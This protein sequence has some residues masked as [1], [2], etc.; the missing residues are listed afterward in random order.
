MTP[1][2]RLYALSVTFMIGF[3]VALFLFNVQRISKT[4]QLFNL[5]RKW[6]GVKSAVEYYCRSSFINNT[7][8][9]MTSIANCKVLIYESTNETN[10]ALKS[11]TCAP[12]DRNIFK[13]YYSNSSSFLA[14]GFWNIETEK[15]KP[16]HF[17]FQPSICRFST[18]P[19][20]SKFITKCL[21]ERNITKIITMGDSNGKYTYKGLTSVLSV[22]VDKCKKITEEE[23]ARGVFW[24]ELSY[25]LGTRKYNRT[26]DIVAVPRIC[27][28]CRAE[29]HKCSYEAEKSYAPNKTRTLTLEHLAM[30]EVFGHNMRVIRTIEDIQPTNNSQDIIFKYYLKDNYPDVLILMMPCIHEILAHNLEGGKSGAR[31]KGFLQQFLDLLKKTVPKSTQIFWVPSHYFYHPN[32]VKTR[33][34]NEILFEVLQDEIASP[35]SNMH[36]TL[37][38]FELGCSMTRLRKQND[39][40]H[41]V[42]TW[43]AT[44]ASHLLEQ[45]CN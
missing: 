7:V 23:S 20:E 21:A 33:L 25:Y 30:N 26:T 22:G 19:L 42:A 44:V 36:A 45:L 6:Y 31:L 38:L 32:L 8:G 27:G 41:M 12:C 18:K 43:Y 24:P 9:N 3:S 4:K 37:D 40:I 17:S 15:G 5:I 28:S 29:L 11:G 13:K 2:L 39:G 1:R 34:C 16:K 10:S 35:D 14:D